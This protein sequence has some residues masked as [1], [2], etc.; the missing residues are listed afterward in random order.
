MELL[1]RNSSW[2][3]AHTLALVIFQA[4]KWFD[5]FWGR[6]DA[7]CYFHARGDPRAISV[8]NC[9]ESD[10]VVNSHVYS[11][12]CVSGHRP[13]VKEF[14]WGFARPDREEPRLAPPLL[15]PRRRLDVRGIVPSSG[16]RPVVVA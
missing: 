7:R 13:S 1:R 14:Q 10:R 16:H 3:F 12:S 4:S 2:L 6:T 5:V 9:Q 11:M 8:P 15:P